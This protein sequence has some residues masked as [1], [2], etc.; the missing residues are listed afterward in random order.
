ME[1]PDEI[2][3]GILRD[4]ERGYHDFFEFTDGKRPVDKLCG[5][6]KTLKSESEVSQEM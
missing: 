3:E 6:I 5:L 2:L 4:E 1:I